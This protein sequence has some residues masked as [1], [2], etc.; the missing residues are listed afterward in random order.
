VG[1]PADGLIVIRTE[2][3]AISGTGH[4]ATA[5]EATE[6][7]KRLGAPTMPVIANKCTEKDLR[8]HLNE[9]G[10][11]HKGTGMKC[12]FFGRFCWHAEILFVFL[13]S[14]LIL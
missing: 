6:E 14:S 3:I 7:S 5:E 2:E 4:R 11:N 1:N 10:H 13:W 9:I 12:R 8:D